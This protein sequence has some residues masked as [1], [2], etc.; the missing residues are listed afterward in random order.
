MGITEKEKDEL[1][2]TGRLPSEAALEHEC[3]EVLRE[4]I[5]EY[6]GLMDSEG[7]LYSDR[8][9]QVII[10]DLRKALHFAL[11]IQKA[12]HESDWGK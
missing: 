8:L 10:Q 1:D 2:R 9:A 12:H 6:P 4:L 3:S 11:R 7:G 5:F